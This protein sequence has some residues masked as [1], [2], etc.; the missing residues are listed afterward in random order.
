MKNLPSQNSKNKQCCVTICCTCLFCE[1]SRMI[2]KQ[3]SSKVLQTPF[4]KTKAVF[5]IQYNNSITN[6]MLNSMELSYQPVQFVDKLY[7]F[8]FIGII[9][10]IVFLCIHMIQLSV[11][12]RFLK[13]HYPLLHSSMNIKQQLILSP[14]LTQMMFW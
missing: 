14:T 11:P 3:H 7:Y 2:E 12:R 5:Y 9:M 10:Q 4:S 8:L 13:I 6:S 1:H